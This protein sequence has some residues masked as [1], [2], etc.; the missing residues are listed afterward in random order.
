V[1]GAFERPDRLR[2]EDFEMVEYVL[3]WTQDDVAHAVH[4]VH[5][6]TVEAGLTVADTVLCG[7]R[8]PEPVLAEMAGSSA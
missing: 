6:R 3:T 7:G 4:H 5:L 1:P 8:W 2:T